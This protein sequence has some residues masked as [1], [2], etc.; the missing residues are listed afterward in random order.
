VERGAAFA[1]EGIVDR[2][3]GRRELACG[4]GLKSAKAFGEF[5]VGQ[6]AFAIEPKKKVLS[7]RIAFLCI[8]S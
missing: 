7:A 6:A 8:T 2:S 1:R 5:S 4:E 3:E